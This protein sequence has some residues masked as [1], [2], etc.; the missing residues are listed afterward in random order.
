M[1]KYWTDALRVTTKERVVR[2]A[3]SQEHLNKQAL[4]QLRV[5]AVRGDTKGA[6]LRRELRYTSV[7]DKRQ[8]KAVALKIIPSI[9]G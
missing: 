4:A 7:V 1:A 9:L 8:V 2:A 6:L 5:E 3:D